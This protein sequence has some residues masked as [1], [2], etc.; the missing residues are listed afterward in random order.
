MS[1][2]SKT[3]QVAVQS[4]KTTLAHESE[5]VAHLLAQFALDAYSQLNL[6]NALDIFHRCHL[7]GGKIV[8]C[9]IGK[10]FKIAAKVVATLKSLSI[11]ADSL[12]PAEALHGDLGL[13]KDLDCLVFFTASGNTPELINLLPHLLPFIPVVLLTCN[14]HSKLSEQPHVKALLYAELPPHLKEDAIHGLPA[15]TVSTTLL[16]V[17]ADAA[18]LALSEMIEADELKRRKTFS[19]KHPGGSI[20]LDLSHLNDNLDSR[21]SYSLLLSLSQVRTQLSTVSSLDSSDNE[22]EVKRRILAVTQP[23]LLAWTE[24]DLLRT[25]AL[26]DAVEM[27]HNEQRHSARCAQL[28][29][30]YQEAHAAKW[31][32]Q[33][34]EAALLNC[35]RSVT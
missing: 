22:D 8:A 9:G 18:V 16:L 4:V 35:F 2:A 32:P 6:A 17:L 23:E 20:G 25:L 21:E 11:N 13:L 12:H 15:P 24:V 31:P 26:Y 33:R 29:R 3:T 28:Q 10:S 19:M 1:P 5:A 14:K 30:L 34:W 7:R 27:T